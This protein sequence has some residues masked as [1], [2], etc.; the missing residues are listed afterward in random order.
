MC[1]YLGQ[2]GKVVVHEGTYLVACK[3]DA[4][5]ENGNLWISFSFSYICGNHIVFK[6]QQVSSD[7]SSKHNSHFTS[8][9]Y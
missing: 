5:L 9:K 7:S 2:R 6:N 4:A 3:S 1:D 8:I